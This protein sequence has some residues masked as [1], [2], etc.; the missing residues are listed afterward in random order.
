MAA[1]SAI[2]RIDWSSLQSK[3]QPETFAALNAFR[4]RHADLSKTLGDL[5]EQS[6]TI[7]FAHYQ[8]VL[9]NKKVATEA[10]KIFSAFKPAAADLSQQLKVIDD[11]QKKAVRV[12]LPRLAM[13][14]R[15]R[16]TSRPRWLT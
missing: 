12:H 3:V 2:S 6:T 8:K 13:P 5:K 15:L 14:K 1:K 10:Q 11:A 7:D 4:K 9:K 16:C